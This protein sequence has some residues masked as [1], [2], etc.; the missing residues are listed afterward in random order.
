MGSTQGDRNDSTPA[1]S[2]TSH[3]GQKGSVD[4]L[5]SEHGSSDPPVLAG[6]RGAVT[7]TAVTSAWQAATL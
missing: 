5:D 3:R 4:D 6:L 2:A 7:C 1:T